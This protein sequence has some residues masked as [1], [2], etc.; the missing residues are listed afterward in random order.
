MC[1]EVFNV[2]K[3]CENEYRRKEE[4]CYTK[5]NLLCVVL[6]SGERQRQTWRRSVAVVGIDLAHLLC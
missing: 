3:M 5:R 6:F 2:D 4:N 1:K